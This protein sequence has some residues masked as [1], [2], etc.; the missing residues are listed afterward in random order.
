MFERRGKS[1]E[2]YLLERM[3]QFL[4]YRLFYEL[5]AVLMLPKPFELILLLLSLKGQVLVFSQLSA[6]QAA[7]MGKC[8]QLAQT[9]LNLFLGCLDVLVDV[10][11]H[12]LAL[13]WG[14]SEPE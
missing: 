5:Q 12:S 8:P 2:A 13:Q 7:L 6:Q 10:Q 1:V 3:V 9:A 14:S 11:S 4:S